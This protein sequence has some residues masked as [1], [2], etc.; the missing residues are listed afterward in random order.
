M[1][2]VYLKSRNGRSCKSLKFKKKTLRCVWIPLIHWKLK[3]YFWKHYSKIIFKDIKSAVGPKNALVYM[4]CVFGWA[5]NSAVGP[6]QK[7]KCLI[8]WSRKELILRKRNA[9]F[10]RM[11]SKKPL[12]TFLYRMSNSKNGVDPLPMAYKII[13]NILWKM[14]ANTI[15][16]FV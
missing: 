6:N 5:L 8:V 12:N 10:I 9:F 14:L 3:I 16:A 4:F 1:R 11:M 15:K 7:R 2:T 13:W